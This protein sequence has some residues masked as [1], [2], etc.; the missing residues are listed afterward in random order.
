M[1]GA[2]AAHAA[3]LHALTERKAR[4]CRETDGGRDGKQLLACIHL[5]AP[6]LVCS[7]DEHSCV[8]GLLCRPFCMSRLFAE[9][10]SSRDAGR[11]MSQGSR[12]GDAMPAGC[13]RCQRP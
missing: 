1:R 9:G 7:C 6:S 8:A 4:A 12:P 3:A 13:A 10:V 2:A 11:R 5:K